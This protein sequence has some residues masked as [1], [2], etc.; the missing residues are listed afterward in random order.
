MKGL[1]LF[2]M[3]LIIILARP[4]KEPEM[5]PPDLLQGAAHVHATKT[6]DSYLFKLGIQSMIIDHKRNFNYKN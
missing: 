4:E 6:I 1:L 3:F 2:L 5:N